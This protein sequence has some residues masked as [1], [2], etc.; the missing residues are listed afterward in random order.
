MS[1]RT[2]QNMFVEVTGSVTAS[3]SRVFS[4]REDV[5]L[6]DCLAE[7]ARIND[8]LDGLSGDPGRGQPTNRRVS[9]V[10]AELQ[11]RLAKANATLESTAHAEGA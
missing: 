9:A 5:S 4:L 11:K 10:V 2:Q 1:M 8:Y 7:L 6:D 3:S